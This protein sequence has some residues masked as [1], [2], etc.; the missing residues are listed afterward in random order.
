MDC[1]RIFESAIIVQIVDA[2]LEKL[3]FM[4]QAL[5]LA[6]GHEIVFALFF[7]ASSGW[8]SGALVMMMMM[9]MIMLMMMILVRKEFFFLGN[10]K[11]WKNLCIIYSQGMLCLYTFFVTFLLRSCCQRVLGRFLKKLSRLMSAKWKRGMDRKN[12]TYHRHIHSITLSLTHH[13]AHNI[14]CHITKPCRLR[15]IST[16]TE[17]P[18]ESRRSWTTSLVAPATTRPFTEMIASPLR[19]GLPAKRWMP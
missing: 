12:T 15:I 8:S 9:L 17:L 13:H 14:S 1:G 2:P 5:E 19:K 4:D 6:D 11:L 16:V 18:P 7:L 3:V 10:H